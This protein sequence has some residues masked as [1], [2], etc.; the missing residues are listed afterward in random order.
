[1]MWHT[2]IAPTSVRNR[3]SWWWC[4][5][6]YVDDDVTYFNCTH[7]RPEQTDTSCLPNKH[8]LPRTPQ[9]YHTHVHTSFLPHTSHPSFYH[10][11][12]SFTTH[13]FC[14]RHTSLYHTPLLFYRTN[15]FTTNI[16]HFYHTHPSFY[17]T[18]PSLYHT[19]P[20]FTTHTHTHTPRWQEKWAGSAAR[21]ARPRTAPRAPR[22]TALF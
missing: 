3:Q 10:T 7:Q 8:I 21:D 1:M 15:F 6:C 17:H 11:H 5:I 22:H 16:P 12:P 20:S 9:F 19:H 14:T 4:D 13:L 18:H 2:S